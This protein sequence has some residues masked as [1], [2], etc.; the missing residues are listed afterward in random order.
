MPTTYTWTATQLVGYP[1]YD[2]LTDVVVTVFYT[3]TATDGSY[4]SKYE[5]YQETPLNPEVPFI[6]Y[7]DLTNDIVIGWVQSALGADGVATIEQ[8]LQ[9]QIDIQINPEPSP[10]V[11]PLPWA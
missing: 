6:P 7:A 1:T 5:W 4:S 3:V 11:L 8:S 9:G 10:E 2:G